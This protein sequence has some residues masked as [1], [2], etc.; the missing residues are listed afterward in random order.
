M[1]KFA[2]F[3]AVLL[4]CMILYIHKIKNSPNYPPAYKLEKTE[5]THM[6]SPTTNH[7]E[8]LSLKKIEI[9]TTSSCPY[10]VRAKRLLTNKNVDFTEIDVSNDDHGRMLMT[11]RTSGRRTVPQIFINDFHVGGC[12]DLYELNDAGKLDDLLK[13]FLKS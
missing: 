12:D 6:S 7:T 4:S 5:F 2:F 11:A 3:A 10:C 9:Y 1:T 13:P 8:T